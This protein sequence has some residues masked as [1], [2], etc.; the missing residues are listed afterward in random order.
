M[1]KIYAVLLCLGALLKVDAQVAC[2]VL[3]PPALAGGYINTWAEPGNGWGTP[4]MSIIANAVQDTLALAHDISADADSLVCDTIMDRAEIEGKIAVLYR[5]TC[6]F[7]LKALFCQDSGAVAVI[8]INNTSAAP[9]TLGAGTY[10]PSVT[11]PTFLVDQAGGEQIAQALR[12]GT[13]VVAR[14]GD[15]TGAFAH[16]IGMQNHDILLPPSAAQPALLA[17]SSSDY[18][19]VLGAWIHNYGN[20]TQ[21]NCVLN[22]TVTQGTNT[23][24]NETS[25]AVSLNPGDSAFAQ[26]PALALSSYSGFYRIH[27]TASNGAGEEYNFDN[28]YNASLTA[29][30]KYALAPLDSASQTPTSTLSIQPNPASGAFT[31]CVPFQDAHASRVAATGIWGRVAVNSPAVLDGQIITATAFEWLDDFTGV[32]D[33]NFA[34][35]Q[36]NDV[37]EGEHIIEGDTTNWTGFIP[38][39]SPITLQDN[40]RYLF[41]ITSEDQTLFLGGDNTISYD[42]TQNFNDQPVV[43]FQETGTWNGAGFVDGTISS[44]TVQMVD[45]N[46]IGIKEEHLAVGTPYPNPTHDVLRIPMRGHTGMA[47]VRILGMDGNK[48]SE[49]RVNVGGNIVELNMQGLSSATYMIDMVFADGAHSS[50][51][52]VLNK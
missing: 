52:V 37:V 36:L 15:K 44:N 2:I 28:L 42:A 11:I 1:K 21:D 33:G 23:V 22:V 8:I 10:G 4:D 45:V 17:Q 19:P 20:T 27:Y 30:D 35:S 40:L 18:S 32:S 49:Q 9:I 5:G 12:D 26:V 31:F 24:Y 50:F 41:C 7:S 48:V 39:N 34:L 43:A 25:T 16:D 46:S 13:T 51:R 29:T 3:E 6:N 14:L 47:T 38:F